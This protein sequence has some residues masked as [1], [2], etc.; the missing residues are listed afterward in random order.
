MCESSLKKRVEDYFSSL[1]PMAHRILEDTETV[2]KKNEDK[3]EKIPYEQQCRLIMDALVKDKVGERYS[4]FPQTRPDVECFPKLCIR[5]GEKYVIDEENQNKGSGNTWRDEH[6]GPFTWETQSQLNFSVVESS[7]KEPPLPR[8]PPP[9]DKLNSAK[10]Y[11]VLPTK[12]SMQKENLAKFEAF[13]A[14]A[15]HCF[16]GEKDSFNTTNHLQ[17]FSAKKIVPAAAETKPNAEKDLT[18]EKKVCSKQR[19]VQVLPPSI[20]GS[21]GVIAKEKPKEDTAAPPEADAV[22]IN[23][24]NMSTALNDLSL[25]LD[26]SPSSDS[27]IPKTGFDF[28]DDW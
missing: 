18:A 28:L 23:G 13:A 21:G 12:K 19:M 5:S 10:F 22:Q 27:D 8:K 4:Y 11:K 7:R 2:K 24:N 15:N 6:S 1:N 9:V 3:W 14:D 17:T 25:N 20:S 16:H 26:L